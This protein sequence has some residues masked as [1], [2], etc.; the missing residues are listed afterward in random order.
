MTVTFDLPPSLERRLAAASR[1]VSAE[2]KEAFAVAL[3]RR[4]E[5]TRPQLCE[6]LGLSRFELEGILKSHGVTEDLVTADELA[7]QLQNEPA[8]PQEPERS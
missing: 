8:Q 6:L 1:D 3:Y 4:G 5:V 2:A 7:L